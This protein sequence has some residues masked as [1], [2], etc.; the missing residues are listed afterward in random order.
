MTPPEERAIELEIEI[1]APPERVWRAWT[2][3]EEFIAW[4]G[5][6]GKYRVT[7]WSGDVRP[8]GSWRAD[9][10]Y[11]DGSTFTV[12]GDYVRVEPPSHLAFTWRPDWSETAEETVVAIDFL[13]TPKGTLPKLRHSGFTTDQSCGNHHQGWIQ[14]LGWL[15]NHL[16]SNEQP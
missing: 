7:E 10:L 5:E 16:Q 9:G 11:P 6:D 13:P 12:G 3:G 1:F 8:G 14:V 2:E 15:R 4:W